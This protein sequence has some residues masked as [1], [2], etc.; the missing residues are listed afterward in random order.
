VVASCAIARGTLLIE[1]DLRI[2]MLS[3][4]RAL[5]D[6]GLAVG[7]ITRRNIREEEVITASMIELPRLIRRGDDVTARLTGGGF[8]IQT[9]ASA[10]DHG[11]MGDL[12]AIRILATGKVVNARVTGPSSVD[13]FE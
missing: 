12:V 9:T 6:T 3:N 8:S 13:I 11:A 4:P 5:M 1:E 10:L 2:E 7:R